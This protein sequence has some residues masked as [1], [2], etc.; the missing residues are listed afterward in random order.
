MRDIHP[1]F[2]AAS[3]RLDSCAERLLLH[4]WVPNMASIRELY[5]QSSPVLFSQDLLFSLPVKSKT[6]RMFQRDLHV[7]AGTPSLG[8]GAGL[9]ARPDSLGDRQ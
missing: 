5:L 8:S 4:P 6:F 2:V 3:L 9:V 1:F 7:M